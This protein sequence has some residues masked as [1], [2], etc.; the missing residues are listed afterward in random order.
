ML[1]LWIL[2]FCVSLLVLIKS[3]DYFTEAAEKIGLAFK[4][5]PFVIG[6]TIISFGTTLP[7]LATSIAAV[8]RDQTEIVAAN[9]IGSNIANI[10]LVVGLAAIFAGTLKVK[11]SLI[12]IDLPLLV[13]A[14]ALIVILAW[15]KQVTFGEGIVGI[16]GYIVYAAYAIKGQKEEKVGLEGIIPGEDIPVTREDRYHIIKKERALTLS[17]IFILIMSAVALYF[18]AVWTVKAIVNMAELLK[19]STSVVAMIALA[20]GTSLPELIV[21]LTAVKKGKFEI[22]LGNVFGANIFNILM[23]IGLL[24]LI[25]TIRI[26]DLTFAVGIPFLIGATILYTFSGISRKIHKW[27]GMMY[28]LIYALFVAKLVGLF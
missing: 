12:D 26:D 14:V 21:C 16:L 2:I 3:A 11:R 25:K 8:V 4:I 5:P 10:L 1:I 22:A 7:E 27:D 20:A 23:I 17:L 24:S 6:L 19:V 18:S 13:A 28:L 15:D 9:A